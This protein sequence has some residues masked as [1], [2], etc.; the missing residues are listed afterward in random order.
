MGLEAPQRSAEDQRW[1]R[2]PFQR[3]WSPPAEL[4]EDLEPSKGPHLDLGE[5]PEPSMDMEV[6]VVTPG[7]PP[8]A[9]NQPVDPSFPPQREIAAIFSLGKAVQDPPSWH[10][11]EALAKISKGVVGASSAGDFYPRR[12]L[13]PSE[14]PLVAR[15]PSVTHFGLA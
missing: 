9:Q 13:P 11:G 8:M 2:G 6:D 3:T 12:A 5:E 14:A 7:D 1:C 4:E 10:K 15:V